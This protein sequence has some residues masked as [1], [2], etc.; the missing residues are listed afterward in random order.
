[1]LKVDAGSMGSPKKATENVGTCGFHGGKCV[2]FMRSSRSFNGDCM[3]PSVMAV[4][5]LMNDIKTRVTSCY[6]YNKHP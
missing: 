4:L 6:I 2:I 1:M 5:L 3:V